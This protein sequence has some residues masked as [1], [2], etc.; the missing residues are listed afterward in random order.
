MLQRMD[1]LEPF[2]KKPLSTMSRAEWESLCD[3]C[4]RCC[5]IKLEDQDSGKIYYTDIVCRLFDCVACRCTDYANRM[6]R[7]RDCLHLTSKRAAEFAWLPRSCAYR[8]LAEGR[9]L[10]WWHPLRSGRSETVV[11]AGVSVKGR[12]LARERDLPI[13][14]YPAHIVD[15]PAEEPTRVTNL[16][17]TTHIQRRRPQYRQSSNKRKM[18]IPI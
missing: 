13:S 18:P 8:R 4:G 5:L 17:N 15:W 1:K 11:A 7:V 2:W 3:G 16:A 14:E 9:G 12:I 10:A 6:K